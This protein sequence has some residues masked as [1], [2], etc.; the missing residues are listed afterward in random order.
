MRLGMMLAALIGLGAGP[1]AAQDQKVLF[2]IGAI[3][4]AQYAVEPDAPPRL[5]HT[6]PDKLA[7]AIEDFNRQKLAF[8][9]HL[10]DFIDKDWASYDALL[11]VAHKL[12]HPWHFVLGNHEFAI[13]D[14][15]KLQVPVKL[16]MKARYY[17]FVEHGWMFIV[18]DGNDLSSYAWP[19]GSAE[20]KRSMEAHAALYAD[21]PL[22][23]GGIGDEQMRWIDAQLAEA[24]RKGLKAML[25]SH[26][27][28]WPEN[29][30]NLWN[31]PAVMALLERHPS[32][33]IWLDGHNHDGNYGVRAGI[34]YV[35]LKAMLDTEETSYAR[36]DFFADH[37]VVRGTGRQQDLTL[38]LR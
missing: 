21:K 27:P 23:D 22:W 25:F 31:A 8:V 34:H 11:P 12:R 17:S 29:P 33:K 9:V 36:L 5:Y 37:V 6:T 35:N 32:A 1:A 4:D 7:A 38:P 2:S 28:L 18:T 19:E 24:D 20:N 26:F 10:G 14:A 3:A 30:H 13:D 16:G 15:H